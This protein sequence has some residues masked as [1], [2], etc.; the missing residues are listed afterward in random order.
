MLFYPRCPT[1]GRVISANLDK[2]CE[3]LDQV[4]SDPNLT[5]SQREEAAAA[6]LDKYGY[7]HLCCRER[8][9]GLE[10]YHEI[11]ET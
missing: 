9:M 10:P 6:L 2:Y 8:I 7:R 11:V 4:R 3:D 1:C 5:K